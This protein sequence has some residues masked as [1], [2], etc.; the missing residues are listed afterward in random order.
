M[1][2]TPA[3]VLSRIP[4]GAALVGDGVA[5]LSEETRRLIPDELFL[6]ETFT[7]PQPRVLAS[8]AAD[9]YRRGITCSAAA[10]RAIYLYQHTCV[11]RVNPRSGRVPRTAKK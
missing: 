9:A 7:R 8:M 1:L 5:L 6:P 10:V 2:A 4:R 11:V 3:E